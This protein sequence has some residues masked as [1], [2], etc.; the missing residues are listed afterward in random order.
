[1]AKSCTFPSKLGSQTEGTR[2]ETHPARRLDDLLGGQIAGT[3]LAVGESCATLWGEGGRERLGGAADTISIRRVP[4]LA[5][6]LS[7]QTEGSRRM[8]CGNELIHLAYQ[9]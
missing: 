4:T 3:S 6:K 1:M 9:F 8:V 5:G 2:S 7:A